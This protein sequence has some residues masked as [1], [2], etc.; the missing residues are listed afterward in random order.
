MKK[1]KSKQPSTNKKLRKELEIK[2]NETFITIAATFGKAKK[3]E[4]LIEKIA[5]QLAKKVTVI[6]KDDSIEPFIK[7][8]TANNDLKKTRLTKVVP[9][10]TAV[11][12]AKTTVKTPTV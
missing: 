1:N 12:K 5:K 11:K 10:K 6:T 2:L 4:K 8:D 9:A 3:A 7:E